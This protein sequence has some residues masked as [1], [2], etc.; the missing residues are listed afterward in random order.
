MCFAYYLL[1][2]V[3]AAEKSLPGFTSLRRLLSSL[4]F[5]TVFAAVLLA[6]R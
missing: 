3:L 4:L 5:C 2:L 6:N 1:L